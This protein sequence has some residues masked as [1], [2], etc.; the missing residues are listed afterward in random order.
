MPPNLDTW[1]HSRRDDLSRFTS[2]EIKAEILRQ[3]IAEMESQPHQSPI[4]QHLRNELAN[5]SETAALAGQGRSYQ[6]KLIA[7]AMEARAT[8]RVPEGDNQM[9][10]LREYRV[11]LDKME[12]MG[13]ARMRDALNM[14]VLREYWR[15]SSWKGR[16]SLIRVH[17]KIGAVGVGRIA[18]FK[19]ARVAVGWMMWVGRR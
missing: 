11:W 19:L 12:E 5:A 8:G 14:D 9:T 4:L 10:V 3:R 13:R 15:T 16:R 17:V 18:S 2:I 7:M 1:L 6:Q